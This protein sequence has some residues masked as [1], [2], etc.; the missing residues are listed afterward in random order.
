LYPVPCNDGVLFI[1]NK[2]AI[3]VSKIELMDVLGNVVLTNNS[4]NDS[5]I[6]LN[7]AELPSGHYFV[8]MSSGKHVSVKKIVVIK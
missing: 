6:K 3:E 2:N 7:L 1:E 4:T 5:K 8:K